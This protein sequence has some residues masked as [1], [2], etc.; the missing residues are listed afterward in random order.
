MNRITALILLLLIYSN[1]EAQNWNL[2]NSQ[3]LNYSLNGSSSVSNQIFVDSVSNDGNVVIQHLNRVACE[4][5]ANYDPDYFACGFC[6]GK[7]NLPQFLGLSIRNF[8]DGSVDLELT[9]GI[10]HLKPL[11][12]SD[13]MFIAS[14][15]E[16][17]TATVDSIT[18]I[19]IFSIL[20]S[21]KRISCSNQYQF[22]ITKNHGLKSFFDGT[23]TYDLIG[24][25]D[26]SQGEQLLSF[27]SIFDFHAGD[28]LEYNYS[29]GEVFTSVAYNLRI[30]VD[31]VIHANDSIIVQYHGVREAQNNYQFNVSSEWV[32]TIDDFSY[33]SDIYPDKLSRIML[34]DWVS[35]TDEIFSI[36]K[37]SEDVNGLPTIRLGAVPETNY[38]NAYEKLNDTANTLMPKYFMEIVNGSY[39]DYYFKLDEFSTL[40]KMGL[41]QTYLF[42]LSFETSYYKELM[43]YRINGHSHGNFSGDFIA[44]VSEAAYPELYV[45]PNPVNNILNFASGS[46]ISTIEIYNPMGV[47]IARK[48]VNTSNGNVDVSMFPDG[49]YIMKFFNERGESGQTLFVK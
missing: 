41:G 30:I 27:E 14:A 3:K 20:D 19:E 31:Q 29:Y 48:Q 28:S 16:G 15:S 7:W 4:D 21:A 25:D 2:L 43:A 17:I 22:W 32:F 6:Y 1:S 42:W 46:F 44:N 49:M 10:F 37:F 38:S 36:T 5:C 9:A 24:I 13:S 45:Y 40:F 35:F 11:A 18:E 26:T 33:L 23:N 39:P 8:D 34:S 12:N 47:L